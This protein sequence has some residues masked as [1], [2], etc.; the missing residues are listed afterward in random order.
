MKKRRVV[1]PQEGLWRRD[2]SSDLRCKDAGPGKSRES[3]L[4][5]EKSKNGMRGID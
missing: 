5:L 1:K 2:S 4:G 3:S